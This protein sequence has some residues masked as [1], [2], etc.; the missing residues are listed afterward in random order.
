MKSL[1]RITTLIALLLLSCQL[2]CVCVYA[3]DSFDSLMQK[4][5]DLRMERKFTEAL[6]Y[7]ERASRLRPTD[8]GVLRDRGECELKLRHFDR[9]I[10]LLTRAIEL[11]PD[12]GSAYNYRYHAYIEVGQMEQAL[13]DCKKG[14]RLNPV[15]PISRHDLVELY[16]VLGRKSEARETE[17]RLAREDPLAEP[18]ALMRKGQYRKAIDVLDREMAKTTN[19]DIKCALL[20]MRAEGYANLPNLNAQKKDLDEVIRMRGADVHPGV[21]WKRGMVEYALGR[22]KESA[23]DL[24]KVLEGKFRRPW[25]GVA[26]SKED[27]IYKRASAY[28]KLKE[29]RKAIADYDKI[30]QKDPR[31]EEAYKCRGDCHQQLGEFKLAIADY[32]K[33]IENDVESAGTHYYARAIA[34]EKLGN[35]E[36][37]QKDRKRAAE[38]GY[39]P[40]VKSKK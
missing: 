17:S 10:K 5:H 12:D 32:D 23:D 31:Q 38:L 26:N 29:F 1:A 27:V 30:L 7:Y 4:G 13:A 28:Y 21:V 9:A 8:S 20:T 16:M 11:S 25:H 15:D 22:Y 37:A 39:V 2:S 33:A 6:V 34:N 40:K 19:T 36:Q 14:Q 24:T 18:A 35:L 3:A